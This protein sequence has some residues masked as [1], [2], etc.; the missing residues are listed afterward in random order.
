M[1]IT[2]LGTGTSTGVPV[3]TCK[4]TVCNSDDPRDNRLR[5]SVLVEWSGASVL[6]D[7]SPDF[8]QQALRYGITRVDAVL[9]THAHADHLL[10]LDDLR[11]YN[12]L[13]G[14]PIPVYGTGDTL[15]ALER[16][17]WYAFDTKPS[18]TTRPTIDLN[19][20]QESFTLLGQEI[21]PIPLMHGSLP[22]IGY[23]IGNLAY[24]TDAS[25]IPAQ[26]L[27]M[28]MGLDTL[29]LN[30]LREQPH[31]THLNIESAIAVARQ[32]GARRTCL[33][34]MSHEVL[35]VTTAAALPQG[36]E[37]AH[38]GLCCEVP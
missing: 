29:V 4:C 23:R 1:R 12:W 15:K 2:F 19:V 34:H 18:D 8:R 11:L 16:T 14:G 13:Q 3:P 35:F 5:P 10:G 17:F 37:L 32:V 6:I 21:L 33:T 27:E 7:S 22:I 28:L 38:D 31:P 25:L 26:S 20:I 30:A 9:Y 24:I 36:I